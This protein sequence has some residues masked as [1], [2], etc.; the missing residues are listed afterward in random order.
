MSSGTNLR[1]LRKDKEKPGL[2]STPKE[3]FE[4]S[5]TLLKSDQ[6]TINKI[7]DKFCIANGI[8]T[9]LD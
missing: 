1:R 7:I 5:S 9:V 6:K 3:Q 2:N 8:K 4:R